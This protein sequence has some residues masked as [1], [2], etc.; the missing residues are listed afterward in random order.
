MRNSF[1][2]T[3]AQANTGQESGVVRPET[4][5]LSGNTFVQTMDNGS[6]I[7]SIKGFV[8]DDDR[9]RWEIYCGRVIP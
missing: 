9:R 4:R 7:L 3:A 8:G 5:F 1:Y 6:G 2:P